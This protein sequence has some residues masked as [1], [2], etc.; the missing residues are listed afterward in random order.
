MIKDL[1]YDDFQEKVSNVLV[2]H[3]SILDIISKLGESNAKINRA[4][5]KSATICGCISINATKQDF[6]KKSM[7]EARDSL[8]NHVDG[9]LCDICKEKIEEELGDHIFY[10][11]SLCNTLNLNLYDILLKE[12]KELDALGIYSLL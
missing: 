2:R 4:V 10:I 7:V 3:K 11:A 6:N 5:I 8:K 1:I 9:E 12:Y